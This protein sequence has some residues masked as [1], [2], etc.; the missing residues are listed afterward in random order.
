MGMD[1]RKEKKTIIWVNSCEKN[2]E[3][4]KKTYMPTELTLQNRLPVIY[5]LK[6]FSTSNFVFCDGRVRRI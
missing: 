5:F 6:K 3:G 2:G 1:F 4:K